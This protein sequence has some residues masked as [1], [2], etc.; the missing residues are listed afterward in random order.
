MPL[1]H[2]FLDAGGRFSRILRH[3]PGPKRRALFLACLKLELKYW[4][5][6]RLLRRRITHETLFRFDIEFFNY[7]TFRIL[8]GEIFVTDVYLFPASCP[9]PLIIDGGANI[10]MSVLY[11]K[12]IYPASHIVAF[13]P[14]PR[15][16]EMLRRNVEKNGL[17][18]VQIHNVALQATAGTTTLY[19]T[20]NSP[21]WLCQSIMRGMAPKGQDET[22]AAAAL[23]DYIFSGVEL[24]KMDIEGAETPVVSELAGSGKLAYVQRIV[25]EYHHH[26]D[27][28]N[29]IAGEFLSTLE[30]NG[31]GYQLSAPL[32]PPF[33]EREL[34][35]FFIYAYRKEAFVKA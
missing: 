16:F 22:V 13:E 34:Q 4:L 7:E 2:E 17:T 10:G 9:T 32:R 5:L 14:D 33:P 19:Y 21:G 12:Y 35:F 11:F 25:L 29:D 23:S 20:A 28:D 1:L 3:S 8:F 24:L 15:T 31:F 27:R 30:R 26:I 6:V 18:N